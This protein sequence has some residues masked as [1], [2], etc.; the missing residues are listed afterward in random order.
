M[1]T[2]SQ[3]WSNLTKEVLMT[4]QRFQFR[5]VLL[6]IIYIVHYFLCFLFAVIISSQ[7]KEIPQKPG[8]HHFILS[9]G[10]RGLELFRFR[11]FHRTGT[12]LWLVGKKPLEARNSGSRKRSRALL[13]L[14]PKQG[15]KNVWLTGNTGSFP[16][17]FPPSSC[18]WASGII[19][20]WAYSPRVS[21]FLLI[22]AAGGREPFLSP[23]LVHL[24]V[25]C[26]IKHEDIRLCRLGFEE[27]CFTCIRETYPLYPDL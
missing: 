18:S 12:V 20:P 17:A 16:F 10:V 19:I 14:G 5:V 15:L 11:L 9:S 3:K 7:M 26:E 23:S 8:K 1:E 22:R 4:T 2:G 6:Y 27:L 13:S 25:F 24:T 21:M